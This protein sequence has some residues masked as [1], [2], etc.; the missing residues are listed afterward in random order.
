MR[1]ISVT[2]FLL[3]MCLAPEIV[4]GVVS[5]ED[6]TPFIV[7]PAANFAGTTLIDNTNVITDGTG[8]SRDDSVSG[9]L[10]VSII[11]ADST[12][13]TIG[14]SENIQIDLE[15]LGGATFASEPVMGDLWDGSSSNSFTRN[16]TA[17]GTAT[18]TFRGNS[19]DGYSTRNLIPIDIRQIAISDTS[20][21]DILV[22]VSSVRTGF[23][24]SSIIRTARFPYIRFAENT[25]RDIDVGNIEPITY[26]TEAESSVLTDT[27][28][29][30]TDGTAGRED[31]SVTGVMDLIGSLGTSI[32]EA[33]DLTIKL[34]LSSNAT[35]EQKPVFGDIWDGNSSQP[36]RF[37]RGGVGLGFADFSVDS[38][39][40]FQADSKFSLDIRGLAVADREDVFLT[41]VIETVD[42][43]STTTL[44]KRVVI[45][46]LR[47]RSLLDVSISKNGSVDTVDANQ[48]FLFF[49]SEAGDTT[50]AVGTVTIAANQRLHPAGSWDLQISDVLSF[51]SFTVEAPGGLSAIS[52]I[53]GGIVIGSNAVSAFSFCAL[54]STCIAAS[55]GSIYPVSGDYSVEVSVPSGNVTAIANTS[56][57]MNISGEA[58][59]GFS[60]TTATVS[61]DLSSITSGD[62]D[63][64]AI[65]D[66]VD[67]CLNVANPGQADQDGDGVGDSCDS[68]QDGDGIADA[69]DNCPTLA[70]SDQRA[71][72]TNPGL[73]F[74][75]DIDTDGDGIL[76]ADDAFPTDLSEWSDIDGD[77]VGDNADDD[78]STSA[79]AYLLT[80]SASLNITRLHIINSSSTPQKFVGTL[81]N[82]DGRQLGASD[83]VL[84][85]GTIGPDARIIL[86]SPDIE[87]LFATS[88][89]QGPAIL[90]VKGTAEFDLMTKLVSPSGLV[91]NTNCVSQKVAFNVEGSDS[92]A[93][94]FVRLINTGDN[95]LSNI[96]AEMRDQ[97]GNRIGDAG[98]EL[99]RFLRAKQ[100]IFLSRTDLEALFGTW[101]GVASLEVLNTSPDIKV[102]NLNFVNNET[103]F[104]FSCFE[105]EE[106]S[107]VYLMTTSQS[108]NISETH[109]IN[110][111]ERPVSLNGSLF[112][113]D[114]T[115]L[116]ASGV[117][118]AD[119]SIPPYGRLIFS[120]S[121][122]EGRFDILPWLGPALLEVSGGE[123]LSL[124][125]KLSSPSGLVSNTNCVRSGDVH[126]IEGSESRVESYVRLI[127]QGSEPIENL[128]GTLFNLDGKIIG[129]EHSIVVEE[130]ASKAAVFLTRSQLADIFGEWEG[131]ASLVLNADHL[132]DLKLL[133]LNL[134]NGETFFN[135]SCYEEA[136]G[137]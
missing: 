77:L 49:N 110:R 29:T 48:D 10:D 101:E 125:T 136:Q 5:E 111:S 26:A 85:S 15:L 124:M 19:G 56:L 115:Q 72:E 102:L 12:S 87:S 63:S 61:G 42:S 40:G 50:T 55:T 104:N 126:N 59:A 68:D 8:A 9:N 35:F 119:T 122:L 2:L 22:T 16:G 44:V 37:V 31:D 23:E 88:P 64:D 54:S 114:G 65:S 129:D 69:T 95:L 130:L 78:A 20:P 128:S 11:F 14:A 24:S 13:P 27:S 100:A 98:V 105:S 53:G 41:M 120:A 117:S 71:S 81:Y 113:K 21:I 3:F 103:Y 112:Q 33:T 82:R 123:Q 127:N 134:V 116:G 75:C 121:D 73:G 80:T 133:N 58:R 45:P 108:N 99:K 47:F 84:H 18:V 74:A 118:L 91:S 89:W 106:S 132:V 6:P 135:F 1:S 67:N 38:G 79:T 17:T 51:L 94:T 60:N 43:E 131:E 62:K 36:F 39:D 109:L 7:I 34:T 83:T 28:D 90:D 52:Q 92:D 137:G 96:K 46:Y 70:N 76:D 97:S 57:K 86:T 107:N 30:I 32:P 93:E 25:A 4:R 66:D